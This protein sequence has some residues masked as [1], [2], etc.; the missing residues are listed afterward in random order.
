M[1]QRPPERSDDD[2]GAVDDTR[3]SNDSNPCQCWKLATRSSAATSGSGASPSRT[4]TTSL[5]PG[6]AAGDGW[7]HRS[8][9]RSTSSA[10]SAAYFLPSLGS[11]HPR[12]SPPLH[13]SSTQS[14]SM[15]PSASGSVPIGLF[16]EATSSKNAPNANTSV[17]VVA[18]LVLVSSGAM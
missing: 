10:S 7:E 14:T 1:I 8:P 4:C 6:L 11:T 16:P 12:I 5:V 17:A 13:F 15:L 18:L 9:S 2:V 3:S